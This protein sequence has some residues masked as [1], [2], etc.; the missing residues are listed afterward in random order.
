[1][2]RRAVRG[3]G[4]VSSVIAC[5]ADI[6]AGVAQLRRV[7]PGMAAAY[8]LTGHPPLRR[9]TSGFEGL[10]QIIVGQQLST[11]SANVIFGRLAVAMAPMEPVAVLAAEE[12]VLKGVGL[13]AA[14][15]ATLRALALAVGEGR[16]DFAQMEGAPEDEVRGQ[17][18]AVR[19]IGPWTADIYLM[20]CRGDAD[21]FAAGDLALQ[22]AAQRLLNLEA[23]PTAEELRAIAEIWRPWRAVA[24]RMLWAYYGHVKAAE[25]NG[26]RGQ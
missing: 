14:K 16:V 11:A 26:G 7:C 22:I 12:G 24:A 13:S 25:A 10:V 9:L 19:G 8:K 2:A 23:R 18:T 6:A 17:L 15:I 1:M 21:A 4:S 20:F 3:K 5:Q